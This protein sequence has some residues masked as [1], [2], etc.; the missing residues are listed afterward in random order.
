MTTMIQG[1]LF[2]AAG[3]VT[4]E[5]FGAAEQEK[6]KAMPV[7]AVLMGVCSQCS[8]VVYKCYFDKDTPRGRVVR[9]CFTCDEQ[10]FEQR[11]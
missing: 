6:E 3:L 2:A 5:T 7:R 4:L 1:E 11:F 9:L 10:F 8:D